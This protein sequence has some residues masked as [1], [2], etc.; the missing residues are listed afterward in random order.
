MPKAVDL[1]LKLMYPNTIVGVEPVVIL[2]G[3]F[4]EEQCH[5]MQS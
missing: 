2:E 5:G 1:Q 3:V 4:Q